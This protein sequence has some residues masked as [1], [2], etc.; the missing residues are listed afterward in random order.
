MYLFI[1]LVFVWQCII[2]SKFANSVVG[3]EAF[4]VLF[5]AVLTL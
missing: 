3:R 1:V 5:N 4:K 2:I